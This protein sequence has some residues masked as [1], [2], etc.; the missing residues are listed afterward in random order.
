MVVLDFKFDDENPEVLLKN[1]RI[2][3][4]IKADLKA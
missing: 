1:E 2:Q 3:E 4:I